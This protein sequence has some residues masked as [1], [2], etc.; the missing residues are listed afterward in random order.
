MFISVIQDVASNSERGRRIEQA[1]SQ[2]RMVV[3]RG[4]FLFVLN[5]GSVA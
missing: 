4:N 1:V 2:T 5:R 3:G